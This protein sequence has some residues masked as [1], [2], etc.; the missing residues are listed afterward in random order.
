MQFIRIFLIYPVFI[1]GATFMVVEKNV[2][3][4]IKKTQEMKKKKSTRHALLEQQHQRLIE[5]RK[6]FGKFT[7]DMGKM[8][9]KQEGPPVNEQRY[10]SF[11]QLGHSF[12]DITR[13]MTLNI[14]RLQLV[15]EDRLIKQDLI[16]S[17][18]IVR[19]RERLN[20]ITNDLSETAESMELIQK[21][22]EVLAT[23]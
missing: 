14:E 10:R 11:E 7:N 15:K 8:A 5:L 1:V 21:R 23:K 3:Q 22:L 2:A 17:Q 4:N 20:R 19:T 12:N 18:E 6:K 9:S 16:I 13:Q